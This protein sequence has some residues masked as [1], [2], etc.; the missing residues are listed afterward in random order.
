MRDLLVQDKDAETKL[1]EDMKTRLLGLLAE[2]GHAVEVVELGRSD[3]NPCLGCFSCMT[4]NNGKCVQ[5]DILTELGNKKQEYGMTIFLTPVLF[6]HLTSTIKAALERGIGCL[7]TWVIIGLGSDITDEEK[8][9]FI[10]L[11]AKHL[12]RVDIVHPGSL[13]E[14]VV[15]VG[16]S[17]ADNGAICSAVSK[18][19]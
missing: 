8:N 16:S 17:L 12:G 15:Y 3:V 18:I 9:T 4:Q 2:K 7:D 6:G 11:T 19:L 1:S 13:K 5:K 14:A 10:D